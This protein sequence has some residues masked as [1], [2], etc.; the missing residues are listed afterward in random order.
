MQ[1]DLIYVI[2]LVNVI[3]HTLIVPTAPIELSIRY[4]V[5]TLEC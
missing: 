5:F 2:L 3:V 1:R 4:V